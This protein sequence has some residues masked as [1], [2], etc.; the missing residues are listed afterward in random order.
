M[1]LR[2]RCCATCARISGFLT[3]VV[4]S[5]VVLDNPVAQ[6]QSVASQNPEINK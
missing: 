1:N 4:P 5:P 6:S 3:V 2:G